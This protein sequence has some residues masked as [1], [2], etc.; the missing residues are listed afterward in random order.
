MLKLSAL[1]AISWFMS[2]VMLPFSRADTVAGKGWPAGEEE[3]PEETPAAEEPDPTAGQEAWPAEY[4]QEA[5][6]AQDSFPAGENGE[7]GAPTC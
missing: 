6:P 2:K 7:G 4:D 5:F 1:P 3:G